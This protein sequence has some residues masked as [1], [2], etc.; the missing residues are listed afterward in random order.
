MCI[1]YHLE[2]LLKQLSLEKYW[3]IFDEKNIRYNDFLKLSEKDLKD[4]GIRSVKMHIMYSYIIKYEYN[5]I[6]III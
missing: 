3:P 6:T 1:D 4:I 2:K 5:R